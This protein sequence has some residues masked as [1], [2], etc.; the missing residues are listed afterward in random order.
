MSTLYNAKFQFGI[1]KSGNQ[2]RAGN[3]IHLDILACNPFHVSPHGRQEYVN[4]KA[5]RFS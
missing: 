2:P 3:A 4:L 5:K 1:D